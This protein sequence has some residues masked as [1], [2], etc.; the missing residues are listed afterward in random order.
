MDRQVEDLWPEKGEHPTWCH[1]VLDDCCKGNGLTRAEIRE[2]A[3]ALYDAG[4]QAKRVQ[5]ML[6]AIVRDLTENGGSL[7]RV[8][9]HYL[10]FPD[11][12]PA[13]RG[14]QRWLG[15]TWPEPK[16]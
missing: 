13:I 15:I 12:E 8:A 10:H 3:N 14:S 5:A 2:W 11:F 9:R 4:F 1:E 16:D 6:P 7:A